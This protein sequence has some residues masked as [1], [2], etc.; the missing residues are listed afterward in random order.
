MDAFDDDAIDGLFGLNML[1]E[2]EEEDARRMEELCR[3]QRLSDIGRCTRG[4][5]PCLSFF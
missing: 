3:R 4:L 1:H 2:A 5:L